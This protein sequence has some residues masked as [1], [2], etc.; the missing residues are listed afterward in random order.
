M[1]DLEYGWE[2]KAIWVNSHSTIPE[3]NVL[4]GDYVLE[5][6]NEDVSYAAFLGTRHSFS[7]PGTWYRDTGALYKIDDDTISANTEEL[8]GGRV[9]VST[10]ISATRTQFV[11]RP[12]FTIGATAFSQLLPG[13]NNR[14]KFYLESITPT[15]TLGCSITTVES[16]VVNGGSFWTVGECVVDLPQNETVTS[17]SFSMYIAAGTIPA[18]HIYAASFDFSVR[19][20]R[21]CGKFVE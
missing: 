18:E 4:D 2:I 17:V 5:L 14:L 3:S 9:A 16:G 15:S 20:F 1:P 7:A 19:R 11:Y 8:P 6:P 10:S 21:I 12:K 13:P